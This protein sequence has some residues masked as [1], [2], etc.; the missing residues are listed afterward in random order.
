MKKFDIRKWIKEQKDLP[1][2]QNAFSKSKQLLNEQMGADLGSDSTDT[3]AHWYNLDLYDTDLSY[4]KG[5]LYHCDN[6][7]FKEILFSSA[8]IDGDEDGYEIQQALKDKMDESNGESVTQH[9]SRKSDY[10]Y[11]AWASLV[12]IPNNYD[13]YTGLSND[14]FIGA[15][16]RSFTPI[17]VIHYCR[18]KQGQFLYILANLIT[19][20]LKQ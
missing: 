3:D 5:Y 15:K 8:N 13:F 9:Y 7:E 16:A 19:Q 20:R 4:G 10:V 1:K 12:G 6:G 14:T 2:D 17:D 11:T 18:E